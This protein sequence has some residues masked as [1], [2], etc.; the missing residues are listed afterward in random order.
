MIKKMIKL[1]N[2]LKNY[3]YLKLKYSNN[4]VFKKKGILYDVGNCL[5][6]KILKG[7]IIFNGYVKFSKPSKISVSE[8]G[9]IEFGNNCFLNDNFICV[10]HKSIKFGDNVSIGP[11]C[12]IFDHDH[13]FNI[14]G[15]IHGKY[16]YGEILVGNNVWIG[17]NVVILKNTKIG[18]NCII[19]A[20]TIVK[21]EIPPNSIVTNDRKM[22]IKKLKE[23]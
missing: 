16:K 10:A 12:S 21:G 18:D 8:N 22:I 3:V 9:I 15:Q 11:N 19:G 2:S 5:A 4:I 20:G 1:I 7:K 13:Y 6:F 17:A 14:N 23:K